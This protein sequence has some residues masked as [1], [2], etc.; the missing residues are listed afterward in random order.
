MAGVSE[1]A[2]SHI[3]LLRTTALKTVILEVC[4]CVF[5][6]EFISVQSPFGPIRILFC[7]CCCLKLRILSCRMQATMTAASP[8][9][10]VSF[11]SFRWKLPSLCYLAWSKKLAIKESKP[12]LSWLWLGWM[13]KQTLNTY[14]LLASHSHTHTC[15]HQADS[16]DLNKVCVWV[17]MSVWLLFFCALHDKIYSTH[18]L[19][20]ECETHKNELMTANVKITNMIVVVVVIVHFHWWLEF[21]PEF[22]PPSLLLV[23]H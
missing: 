18:T 13:G 7:C 19:Y 10:V 4:V 23:W 11:L 17:C 20:Y 2:S 3:M 9:E 12:A 8:A 15:T 16:F 6:V 14:A 21:F 1:R 5:I 22:L